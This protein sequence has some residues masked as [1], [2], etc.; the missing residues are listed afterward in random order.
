MMDCGKAEKGEKCE[1]PPR[2]SKCDK[3]K[4]LFSGMT[5]IKFVLLFVLL[6]V[7]FLVGVAGAAFAA[8]MIHGHKDTMGSLHSTHSEIR[9]NE[10][11]DSSYPISTKTALS[12]IYGV[13]HTPTPEVVTKVETVTGTTYVTVPGDEVQV[14]ISVTTIE[15]STEVCEIEVVTMTESYTVTVTPTT[16]DEGYSAT[17]GALPEATVIGNPSTVTEVRTDTS[18]TSG[19]PDATISGNPST[20]TEVRVDTSFTSGLPDAT[21]SGNPETVTEG[22]TSWT[23]T[24]DLPDATVPG[25]PETV[26]EIEQSFTVTSGIHTV[27]VITDLYPPKQ[28]LSTVTEFTTIQRT[29]TTRKSM[30]TITVTDLYPGT[31]TIESISPTSTLT[32]VVYETAGEASTSTKTIQIPASPYPPYPTANNSMVASPSGSVTV[33]PTMPTPVVISG[34]TKK[35]EP[36]GWG[37]SS[38]TT[39]LSCIVMLVAVVMFVL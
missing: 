31:A 10:G 19:L 36:R 27:V 37:G 35:P 3:L 18:F 20:V 5:L 13:S 39:N 32:K 34:G 15:S 30:I 16:P 33:L 25:N 21:V 7:V 2:V 22:Q 29:L 9:R 1:E 6:V 17:S 4:S 8:K 14:S 28:D 24:S 12:T 23:V 38:G 26:T 11:A